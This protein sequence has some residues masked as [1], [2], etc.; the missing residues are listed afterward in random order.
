MSWVST[1]S[2]RFLQAYTEGLAMTCP[3]HRELGLYHAEEQGTDGVMIAAIDRS[4]HD[5]RA[6][7]RPEFA[8]QFRDAN[9]T[10]H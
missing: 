6:A 4:Q 3:L 2:R 8:D 7:L 10:R 9:R 1:M 5:V